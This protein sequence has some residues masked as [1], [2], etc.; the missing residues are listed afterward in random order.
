MGCRQAAKGGV[1]YHCPHTILQETP[2]VVS[3]R[4]LGNT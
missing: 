1:N 3:L 4:V 2:M